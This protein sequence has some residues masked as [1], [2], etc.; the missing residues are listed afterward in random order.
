VKENRYGPV[1]S[2]NTYISMD[3]LKTSTRENE[4]GFLAENRKQVH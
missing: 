1:L 2:Q 4:S 3:G